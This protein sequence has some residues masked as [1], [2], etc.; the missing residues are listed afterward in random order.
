MSRSF[1]RVIVVV[2][3]GGV[4]WSCGSERVTVSEGGQGAG[5]QVRRSLSKAAVDRGVTQ[6]VVVVT[7]REDGM[8]VPGAAVEF[9][10]SISGRSAQYAW[11]GTTDEAGRARVA[12]GENA[13]G[14]YQARAR[15]DG[16]L[17]GRWSSIPINGGYEVL[18]DLAVGGKARVTGSSLL[19]GRPT[20][21]TPAP[22]S[23]E[24]FY[25]LV[26]GHRMFLDDGDEF[27]E[28]TLS[29]LFIAPGRH[30]TPPESHESPLEGNYNYESTGAATG[31]LVLYVD[32]DNNTQPWIDIELTFESPTAGTILSTVFLGDRVEVENVP[33]IFEIVDVAGPLAFTFDFGRGPQGFVADFADYPPEHAEIYELTADYRAI[34]PPLDSRSGLFISGINRSDD[35]FMFYRGALDGLTPGARYAA[36]VSVEI[37]TDTPSGCVGVGGSPGESVWIKAGASAEEPVPVRDGN[38]LRMNV[39][40]GSQSNSGTQA[41]VLGNVANSRTCDEPRRWETKAL[42]EQDVSA[43]LLVPPDG[44]TWLL[45][46]ADSGFESLTQVYFTRVSVTLTPL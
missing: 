14:Y 13:T 39:N 1:R 11:S 12:L 16:N 28:D 10:R 6:A 15:Q 43:P 8:P 36:T 4:L 9:S 37:A 25:E 23:P 24:A 45:I 27:D 17:L 22:Q 29:I 31:T 35:L 38:Y 44:R 3:A 20:A 34:P 40:V 30:S 5:E 42:A 18:L 32:G 46:G 2:L 19:S 21:P 7:V 41:V 33:G 26:E